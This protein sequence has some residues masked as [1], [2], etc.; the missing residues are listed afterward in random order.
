M[1]DDL[2][3]G[4]EFRRRRIAAGLGFTFTAQ[5]LDIPEKTLSDLETGKVRLRYPVMWEFALQSLELRAADLVRRWRVL[6][7]P[8]PL[9][10]RE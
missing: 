2:L 6:R 8:L 10:R 9:P 1:P 4:P 7:K 5:L 3:T